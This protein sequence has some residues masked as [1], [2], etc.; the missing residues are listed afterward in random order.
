MILLH[1]HQALEQLLAQDGRDCPGASGLML[2]IPMAVEVAMS[3]FALEALPSLHGQEPIVSDEHEATA[4]VGRE[5][6]D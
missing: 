1:G 2:S 6:I 4:E 5:P 3:H